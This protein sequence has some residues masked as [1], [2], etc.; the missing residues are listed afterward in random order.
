MGGQSGDQILSNAGKG[1]FDAL[2]QQ[3]GDIV[4][5]GEKAVSG[6][7]GLG[8]SIGDAMSEVFKNLGPVMKRIAFVLLALI[9]IAMAFALLAG[10]K[11]LTLVK[12]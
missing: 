5:A 11:K 2:W 9:L 1:M 7:S 12:A 6:E 4:G 3:G 10:D 8:K